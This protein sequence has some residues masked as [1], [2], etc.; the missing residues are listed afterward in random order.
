[1]PSQYRFDDIEIDLTT[2]R[3]LKAG[4]AL[5]LEPKT[6]S[7]LIFLVNNRSRLVAKRELLDA[8]WNDAFVTENVLSRAIAQLRKALGDGAKEGRYI[9]TV[10]TQGYRFIADVR[11]DEPIQKIPVAQAPGSRARIWAG[12]GM[13]V[14]LAAGIAAWSLRP[15]P[16][17]QPVLA[18]APLTTFRGIQSQ[19]SFSPD[20]NQVAFSW[21]G[22]NGDNRDIYVKVLGSETPLR[23]TSDPAEDASPAWSPDG[24]TIAFMRI[25][26]NGKFDLMLIPALGGPERKLRE[27]GYPA[28]GYGVARGILPTWSADSKWLVVGSAWPDS[29]EL[30][31]F[32]VSVESGEAIQITHPGGTLADSWPQISPDGKT[33]LFTRRRLLVIG[34]LFTLALDGNANPIG[35]P[36]RIPLGSLQAGYASWAA[37]GR[38]IVFGTPEGLYRIPEA[39]SESP[40]PLASLGGDVRSIAVSRTGNR[41]AYSLIRGDANIW[42]IDL[43]SKLAGPE[44]PQRLLASTFRDAYPQYSPDGTRIAFYSDRGGSPQV[45]MSNA[46]GGQAHQLAFMQSGSTGT[47]HWSP[48]GKTLALDSNASGVYQVYTM[49]SDGGKLTQLTQ[50]PS[51]NFA[52]TWSRDGRWLYFCSNHTGRNEVWKM[53]SSGGTAVQVTRNGG[54]KAVESFDGR[55]IYFSKDKNGGASIWKMPAEGG[56]ET[57]LAASVYRFNFAVANLGIYYMTEPGSDGTAALNF[58]SFAGGN[59]STI[60]HIGRPEFGLDVSPDGR[61][62]AYAQLDD[63]G[64][65][66]MLVENFR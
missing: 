5:T 23:L 17:E 61:Y 15:K 13:C 1:M 45:W 56:P 10:P 41:L 46:D 57:L 52:A 35:Q 55:S 64:S 37:G 51:S 40:V 60:A 50:G 38:E 11:E 22:E 66:L 7:V 4:R 54:V 34:D 65:N 29:D 3:V 58:Y 31:L 12:L 2:Y 33:M 24:R 18:P 26:N 53:P 36:H 21:N 20:G 63:A 62:L 48:D 9:E 42:R 30:P 14:I 32:K 27:F 47:P 43:T 44:S 16:A 25:K 6:F 39:G 8:V 28:I 59:T 49:S 19:P